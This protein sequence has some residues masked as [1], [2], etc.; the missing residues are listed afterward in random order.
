LN[1]T[2]L[3]P[4]APTLARSSV[5]ASRKAAGGAIDVLPG[6][7]GELVSAVCGTIFTAK[8]VKGSKRCREVLPPASGEAAD[9]RAR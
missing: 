5:P 3:V 1:R 4:A 7:R 2:K 6:R 9:R 8:L